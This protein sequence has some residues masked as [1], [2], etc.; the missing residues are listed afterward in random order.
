MV[1][2]VGDDDND[3]GDDD[4]DEDDDVCCLSECRW[5]FT[6]TRRRWRRET[7]HTREIYCCSPT[8]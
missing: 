6:C 1:L 4:D 5:R 7:C 3:D 8:T 2:Q